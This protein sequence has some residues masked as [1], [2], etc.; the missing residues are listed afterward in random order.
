M[1]KELKIV[2]NLCYFINGKKVSK[3]EFDDV[4]YNPKNI[5]RDGIRYRGFNG[6]DI[7]VYKLIERVIDNDD[8]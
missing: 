5:L 6:D 4:F 7:R 8:N 2:N 3:R 1:N